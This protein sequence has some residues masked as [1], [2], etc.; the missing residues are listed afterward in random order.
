MDLKVP[1]G[2]KEPLEIWDESRRGVQGLGP[3]RPALGRN[4]TSAGPWS[5]S[6]VVSGGEGTLLRNSLY[7]MPLFKKWA[8]THIC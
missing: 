3:L 8:S 2:S 5:I 1:T 6:M 4:R 7:S